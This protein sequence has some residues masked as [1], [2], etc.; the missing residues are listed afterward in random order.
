MK[1]LLNQQKKLFINDSEKSGFPE[2]TRLV[3]EVI[4]VMNGK[5]LFVEEHYIRLTNT[6]LSFHLQIG[7]S[8]QE[9]CICVN[10][11]IVINNKLEGNIKVVCSVSET[12]NF[13]EFSFI[14]HSYPSE[15]EY[16][17]GIR[18]DLY[19]AEREDPNAK[20]LRESF[21]NRVNQYIS[22]HELYEVLLVDRNGKITEGSR[23]NVFFVKENRFF[24]APESSVLVGI[25]RQKVIDCLNEL[26][27]SI[28]EIAVSAN[29]IGK[30]DACFITGT[31]PKV[32]PVKT[33]NFQVFDTQL[34]S[35]NELMERY[36]QMIST[37][38][39][40]QF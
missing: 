20:V 33:I 26:G 39:N 29:D 40:S 9:F 6:I 35:V 32:L 38:I 31:S 25:T 15:E 2:S 30:Y 8:F 19:F 22:D 16:F 5:V 4:R 23:S 18:T 37:N 14:P 1:L 27:Y 11:I 21:R 24:T 7:L 34:E 13:W 28:Q 10:E 17:N 12:E 3:Y 36:N